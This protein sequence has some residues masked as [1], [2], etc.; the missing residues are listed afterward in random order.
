[1]R[2]IIIYHAGCVDGFT[3]AWLL[4][5]VYPA[6][7]F[8]AAQHGDDPPDDELL[9]GARVI[10][11]DFSFPRETLERINSLAGGLF[12][13]DHHQSAQ[14]QLSGLPYC[15]FDPSRCGAALVLGQYP[16]AT[17][18][19][20]TSAAR[21]VSYVED[22]DLWRFELPES[23]AVRL[24]FRTI[25]FEF[26]AWDALCEEDEE[27]WIAKGRPIQKYQHQLV[28][29]HIDHAREIRL[30][31]QQVLGVPCTAGTLISD[32]GHELAQRSK[33]QIGCCWFETESGERVYSLRSVGDGNA[34][35]IAKHY[36][37]GG[38]RHACGFTVPVAT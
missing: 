10:I 33:S 12:L 30:A 29:S 17:D 9:T 5:K 2:T 15:M 27:A 1:M 37:G 25:P 35:E 38:H 7:E 24:Y 14:E 28:N 16:C 34:L 8:V 18:V 36:G 3:C 23:K 19:L 31:G 26:S 11:A 21:F 13:L 22:H 6:A 32:I 4:S 20:P